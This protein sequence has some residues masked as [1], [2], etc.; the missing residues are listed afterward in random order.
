MISFEIDRDKNILIIQPAGKLE[1][2]DFDNL[3]KSVDP[4]IEEV[5]KLS[6]LMIY[7]ESFPGW[8]DFGALVKHF[9]F[10]K[11]HHKKIGK[12]AAVTDSKFISIA[13]RVVDHFVRAELKHFDYQDKDKALAWLASK[14]E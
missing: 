3:A 11:E 12:V 13:P 6:G 14:D 1:V 4:Y 7:T 5:G 10:V 8:Q 2:S 9:K